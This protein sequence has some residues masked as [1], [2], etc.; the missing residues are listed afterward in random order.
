MKV[1]FLIRSTS[2]PSTIYLRARTDYNDVR[3]ATNYQVNS[4]NWSKGRV[5]LYSIG[6]TVNVDTQQKRK[7]NVALRTLQTN[8]D[9]LKESVLDNFHETSVSLNKE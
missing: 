8:L 6:R 9:M 3:L 1:S 4:E 7:E 2:N 5:K